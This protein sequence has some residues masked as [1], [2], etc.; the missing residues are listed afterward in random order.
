MKKL[1][2]FLLSIFMMVMITSC[3]LES[4]LDGSWINISKEAGIYTRIL[5]R[6]MNN[7]SRGS[8]CGGFVSLSESGDFNDDVIATSELTQEPY[9]LDGDQL[10][11]NLDGYING[12]YTEFFVG[13]YTA[14]VKNKQL[15]L[16]DK[17]G[18]SI[19]FDKE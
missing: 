2:F 6:F 9:I 10:T 13:T 3:S 14:E 4:K 16:T 15:T 8:V 18:K 11:L 12:I 17:S 7:T 19:T 5:L 1:I